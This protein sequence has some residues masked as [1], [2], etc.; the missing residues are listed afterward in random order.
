MNLQK[1]LYESA[2]FNL[3]RME[4]KIRRPM[5]CMDPSYSWCGDDAKAS[6]IPR[7]ASRAVVKLP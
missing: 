3:E 5:R 7:R 6:Q 2:N 4:S 1:K